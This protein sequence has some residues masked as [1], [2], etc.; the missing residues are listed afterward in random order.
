MHSKIPV[1]V[2]ERESGG[3]EV[4]VVRSLSIVREG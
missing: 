3:C 4:F 1:D 2:V